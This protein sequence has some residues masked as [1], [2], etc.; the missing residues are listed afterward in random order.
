MSTRVFGF[1]MP[2]VGILDSPLNKNMRPKRNNNIT[3]ARQKRHTLT[4]NN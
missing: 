1:S 4:T 2:Y 3:M